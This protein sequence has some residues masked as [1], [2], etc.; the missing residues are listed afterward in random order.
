MQVE[1]MLLLLAFK[2]KYPENFFILR[3]NH[4]CSSLAY[5]YGFNKALLEWEGKNRLALAS[6][7]QKDSRLFKKFI[8]VFDQLPAAALVDD[9]ILCMHGGLSQDLN[10]YHD[11]EMI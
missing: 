6:P 1:T 2:V 8:S 9:K 4:E 10:D 7:N 3:G 5:I 11:I